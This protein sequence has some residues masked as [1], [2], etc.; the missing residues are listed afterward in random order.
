MPEFVG[1]DPA[2][3]LAIFRAPDGSVVHVDHTQ[4]PAAQRVIAE[5]KA[6]AT[7]PNPSRAA[8]PAY[9]GES[10]A[11][12]PNPTL[13]PRRPYRGEST[14]TLPNPGIAPRQAYPGESRA[15]LPNPPPRRR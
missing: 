14:A 10:A 3:G 5:S 7:A 13:V 15:T 11:Q 9:P 12:L 4:S 2:T 1:F 6:S 8:R